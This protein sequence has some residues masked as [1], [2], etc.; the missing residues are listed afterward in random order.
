[1]AFPHP[2]QP[3]AEVGPEF[4]DSYVHTQV[5]VQ[6]GET[7]TYVSPVSATGAPREVPH[8]YSA[9]SIPPVALIAGFEL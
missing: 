1:M 5:T 7:R 6:E 8:Y 9:M 4:A 2:L 3:V